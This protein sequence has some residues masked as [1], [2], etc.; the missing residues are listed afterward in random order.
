MK[1]FDI[2][3]TFT[4]VYAYWTAREPTNV[5]ISQ[6]GLTGVSYKDTILF[7]KDCY[8]EKQ[9][10]PYLKHEDKSRLLIN[11]FEFTPYEEFVG[12]TFNQ[13]FENIFIPGSSSP[14]YDTFEDNVAR[15]RKQLR[16]HQ[17]KRLLEKVI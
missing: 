4:E 2:R 9:K 6:T 7:W 16:E 1:V 8:K 10:V 13:K 17:V 15:V 11:D 14:D 12:L 3:K 5:K